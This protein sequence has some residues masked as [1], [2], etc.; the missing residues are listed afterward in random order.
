MLD[1][2]PPHGKLFFFLVH[3]KTFLTL[4][5][6]ENQVKTGGFFTYKNLKDSF[7]GNFCKCEVVMQYPQ[8]KQ[9]RTRCQLWQKKTHRVNPCYVKT[10]FKEA[11]D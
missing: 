2:L 5:A 7:L 11:E 6:L 3:C 1:Y 8:Q 9:T 4:A 10:F